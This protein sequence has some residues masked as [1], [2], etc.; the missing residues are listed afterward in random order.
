MI[1]CELCCGSCGQLQS[2]NGLAGATNADANVAWVYLLDLKCEVS[3]HV[4]AIFQVDRLFIA[5]EQ[6]SC[7]AGHCSTH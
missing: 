4:L 1:E 2:G 7:S 3:E 5:W 6:C